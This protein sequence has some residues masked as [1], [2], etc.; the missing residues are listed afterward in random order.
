VYKRGWSIL[1]PARASTEIE[2]LWRRYA[3]TD[4]AFQDET[5][6]TDADW[7][8]HLAGA[9]LTRRLK[10]TWTGTLRADQGVR[11]SG[12]AWQLCAR[13][14]LRR[15]LIGVE[16]GSQEML[17][18]MQK[19]VRLDDVLRSAE[20]CRRHSIGA[21]FPFIVGFPGETDAS[22]EATLGLAKRLRRMSPRFETPIFYYKPYPGS[23]ITSAV[24]RSGYALPSSLNE[25]AE[26]EFV[27]S[28]GPWVS[29]AKRERIERFKFYSRFAGGPETWKRWPLQQL[30][31]WRMSRDFYGMPV[32]KALVETL[33]PSPDLA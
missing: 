12:D 21:I 13:S 10:F 29:A 7:I 15:V 11:L 6:F 2:Q 28:S 8:A 26:F 24:L 1:H 23:P 17:D 31:R 3:F 5:L 14:G 18:W 25:W 27:S 32:E 16:S 20:M 22:V 33:K 9:F 4:L 30:A 19:D